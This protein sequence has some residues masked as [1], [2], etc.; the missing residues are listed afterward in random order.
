MKC[1]HKKL[2]SFELLKIKETAVKYSKYDRLDLLITIAF[3]KT[4]IENIKNRELKTVKK[5]KE[6]KVVNK[7]DESLKFCTGDKCM[8]TLPPQSGG[9]G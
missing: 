4:E 5:Q 1:D 6:I 2:T 7:M 3:T 8:I 9:C